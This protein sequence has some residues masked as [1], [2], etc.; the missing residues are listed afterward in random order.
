MRTIL[1]ADDN[2]ICRE[3][4]AATLRLNHYQTLEA[5]NGVE[6]LQLAME[7]HP[8]LILLDLSM[9][10]MDGLSFLGKLR[11]ADVTRKTP[12]IVLTA[13]KDREA[14]LQAA[15]MGV[16]SFLLKS[17]FSNTELISRVHSILG[18]PEPDAIEQASAS[19]A[20]SKQKSE[21]TPEGA[22]P[23]ADAKNAPA[24]AATKRLTKSQVLNRLNQEIDLR[25]IKPI[26]EYVI[27]LTRSG[28]STLEDIAAAIRQDQALSLQVL[29]VANSS[30]YQRGKVSKN[31]VEA[32][33]RIGL[34]AVRNAVIAILSIEH[35]D[36]VTGAGLIPQRF[37]EH[38]LAT[39]VLAEMIGEKTNQKNADQLF[40]AGL[41]HDIGRM[42]MGT[43][44][45]G[46]Y[47]AVIAR[48]RETGMDL[49]AVEMETFEVS[50]ADAT[51]ALLKHWNIS[52][53]IIE[54][55]SLHGAPIEQLRKSKDDAKGHLAVALANRMAHALIA[56]DSGNTQLLPIREFASEL[57]LDQIAIERLGTAAL[58]KLT[59]IQLFYAA[60]SSQTFGD[61]LGSELA[62]SVETVP[63]V[64]VLGSDAPGDPFSLFFNQLGWLK[65]EQ[66]TVAIVLARTQLDLKRHLPALQKL[67]SN[68]HGVVSLVVAT[69]GQ[70]LEIP[71]EISRDRPTET[72]SLPCDYSHLVDTITRCSTA[73]QDHLAAPVA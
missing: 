10:V 23:R 39:G 42:V 70:D 63:S 28:T 66:P 72:I 15:K 65:P 64:V 44:L 19:N 1:V 37:W 26:L 17:N 33:Q 30:F 21:S 25:S 34:T 9:P 62:G 12:V 16:S 40:L 36:Q 20:P 18:E 59:D 11:G 4:I 46:E 68:D 38:S 13:T 43:I 52:P 58:T 61:S 29:R 31:L 50:H 32:T 71:P 7:N 45:Q 60:Q 73:A 41:L 49:E 67:D 24:T 2:A 8:D 6:A 69:F 14:V 47:S 35:F 22:A 3:P 27:A 5:S 53:S 55:A 48:A 56:G 57:G 51:R 54:A